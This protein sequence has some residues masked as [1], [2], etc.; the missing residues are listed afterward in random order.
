M[1]DLQ[2]KIKKYIDENFEKCVRYSPED[3]GNL[4]GMPYRY[5]VPS[6]ESFNELYYWDTYFTNVGL[7][8]I[9]KAALAKSNVDNM[10]YLVDKFGFMPNG[11]RTFY[12]NRS[13]P[14][15]LSEMVK[16]VYNYFKDRTWL[17]GAYNTL[18]K[19]YDFWQNNRNSVIGLN[20]Y[21]S[22][23][24]D[25]TLK[26]FKDMFIERVGEIPDNITT[27]IGRHSLATAESGWDMTP[28]FEYEA[29]NYAA[30]DLNS[31]LYCLE[32]NME[33]FSG[34][35]ENGESSVWAERSEK[36]RNL[37]SRYMVNKSGLLTDYNYVEDKHS[38]IFSVASYFAMF[39]GAASKEQAQALADNLNRIE[40]TCGISTCERF[41]GESRGNKIGYQWDYPN[42]WACLQYIVVK[43]LANYGY[44]E[45]AAR[46]AEKYVSLVEKIFEKTENFWEK[47]NVSDGTIN[48]VN[49]YKMPTMLGWS[50][51]VYIYAKDFLNN[52]K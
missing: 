19:E 42:G 22:A 9:G 20:H 34:I 45:D 5:T 23:Y 43:G 46:I 27:D 51:G 28:R 35:L 6:T 52:I 14:P 41:E 31:L 49:E 12:L 30:I 7:L 2:A 18:L 29:Y 13:Q 16:D 33:Y 26:E 10:L 32:K 17:Y 1:N 36:R 48:V 38:P 11:S 21:D 40:E 39:A 8:K 25:E 3:N 37:M 47:Y 50:A 44:I 24:T 4:I 15:F